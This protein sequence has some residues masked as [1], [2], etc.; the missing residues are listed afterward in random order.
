MCFGR[1][2]RRGSTVYIHN[3]I[4][5]FGEDQ[6]RK[7]SLQYTKKMFQTFRKRLHIFKYVLLN[8][9]NKSSIVTSMCVYMQLNIKLQFVF[10]T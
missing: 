9:R 4:V 3:T 6:L 2:R 8:L 7:S 1:R 5:L 10:F